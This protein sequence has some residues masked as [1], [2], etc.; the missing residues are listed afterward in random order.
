MVIYWVL[1]PSSIS[2]ESAAATGF[3]ALVVCMFP[4]KLT[5]CCACGGGRPPAAVKEPGEFGSIIWMGFSVGLVGGT[6]IRVLK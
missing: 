3:R 4:S 6:E 1:A 2:S 5:R